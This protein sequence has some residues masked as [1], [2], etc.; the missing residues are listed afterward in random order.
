MN[1]MNSGRYSRVL[2]LSAAIWMGLVAVGVA[3]IA[4][5]IA[6]QL[7]NRWLIDANALVLAAVLAV[8]CWLDV[9]G[10]VAWHN[11]QRCSEV[12]GPAVPIDLAYL[13]GF[14]VEV[15]PALV[16]LATH[17]REPLVAERA[18]AMAEQP[19]SRSARP[20]NSSQISGPG[21]GCAGA[22]RG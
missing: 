10:L 16:W 15:A 17:S 19:S 7:G 22:R 3:L 4:L 6:L 5:R 11:V 13:D 14:G 12:G 1:G 9:G 18:R 21:P 8:C 2:P 20:G